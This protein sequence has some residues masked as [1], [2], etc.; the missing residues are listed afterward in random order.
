M[1]DMKRLLIIVFCLTFPALL[2]AN[3]EPS[4][5]KWVLGVETAFTSMDAWMYTGAK[6]TAYQGSLG[7]KVQRMVS[8]VFAL[9]IRGSFA[10]LSQGDIQFNNV[11]VGPVLSIYMGPH[12]ASQPY[13]GLFCYYNHLWTSDYEI[14]SSR[15][16]GM[17]L[18][19]GERP[20][21]KIY[22]DAPY[23]NRLAFGMNFGYLL[24]MSD[25]FFLTIATAVG[26]TWL[27]DEPPVE[28]LPYEYFLYNDYIDIPDDPSREDYGGY[29][30]SL[31]IGILSF[32]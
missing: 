17:E 19:V 20:S 26:Y 1:G 3:D 15:F 22:A 13:L 23:H 12:N 30:I 9:G 8:K 16:P 28:G 2:L 24:R 10:R 27:I 29:E 14:I 25:N 7:L 32:L 5:K 31:Q 11:G 4:Q 18:D 21:T 6:E